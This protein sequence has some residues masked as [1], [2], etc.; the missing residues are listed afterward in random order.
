MIVLDIFF[1]IAGVIIVVKREDLGG[2]L[3]V[4]PENIFLCG[5]AFILWGVFELFIKP[6]MAK[7]KGKK[8]K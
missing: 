4:P 8:K 3:S 1:I 6:L 5:M 7:S 2:L